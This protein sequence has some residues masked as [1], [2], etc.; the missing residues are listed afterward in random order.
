[1]NILAHMNGLRAQAGLLRQCAEVDGE[2]E[3]QNGDGEAE[4]E[5]PEDVAEGVAG[6]SKKKKGKSG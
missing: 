6:P 2:L 4:D 5:V 3:E 1:M